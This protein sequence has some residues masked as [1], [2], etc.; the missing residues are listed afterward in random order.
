MDLV[1]N[2]LSW[3]FLIYPFKP[4]LY[5]GFHKLIQVC[6]KQIY[7]PFIVYRFLVVSHLRMWGYAVFFQMFKMVLCARVLHFKVEALQSIQH[8]SRLVMVHLSFTPHFE[9]SYFSRLFD[10]SCLRNTETNYICWLYL[11]CVQ[12][13]LTY[14]NYLQS[15]SVGF[16]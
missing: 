11:D 7:L 16:V 2:V 3:L 8:F 9:H 13:W 5:R 1:F 10:C 15:I 6:L 4:K 12:L 14:Q